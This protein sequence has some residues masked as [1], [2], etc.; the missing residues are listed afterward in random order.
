MTGVSWKQTFEA[1][2]ESDRK[3]SAHAIGAPGVRVA[4]KTPAAFC[5]CRQ[6]LTPGE[7]RSL[8]EETGGPP[9]DGPEQPERPVRLLSDLAVQ[10]QAPMPM[11][12]ARCWRLG[13]APMPQLD[14]TLCDIEAAS[15]PPA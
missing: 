10:A 6:Q 9:K 7:G 2:P 8:V 5:W 14:R 1:S 13:V 11:C 15:V 4:W 12:R 3:Q